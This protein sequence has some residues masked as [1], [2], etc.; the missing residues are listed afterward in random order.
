MLDGNS[1]YEHIYSPLWLQH[2]WSLSLLLAESSDFQ[3][4]LSA[5]PLQ[6]SLKCRAVEGAWAQALGEPEP[7]FKQAAERIPTIWLRSFQSLE[8]IYD[9]RRQGALGALG[10]ESTGEHKCTLVTRREV[11]PKLL[12][13]FLL[14]VKTCICN[15][16]HLNVTPFPGVLPYITNC[17]TF[18]FPTS[19]FTSELYG[20][21]CI[22][23]KG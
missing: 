1:M 23:Q 14:D 17:N 4:S 22:H 8:V 6:C 18:R 10:Q 5:L 13:F 21:S 16:N 9:V 12:F 20:F 19:D 7:A 3:W 11:W 2:C 15:K